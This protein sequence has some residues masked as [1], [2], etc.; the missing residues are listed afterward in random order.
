MFLIA[1]GQQ[2]MSASQTIVITRTLGLEKVAIWSVGTRVFTLL[3]LLTRRI[4][5]FSVPPLAEILVRKEHAR[6]RE[7]FKAVTVL[8][9][10]VGGLAA[11]LAGACNASFVTFW[12]HG[13]ITWTVGCDVLLG[14]WLIV[15]A[16]QY[17]HVGFVGVTKDI[18]FARWI[19][20]VEGVVFVVLASFVARWAGLAGIIGCSAVCTIC[21]SGAYGMRRSCEYF[22]IPWTEPGWNWLKP[23]GRTLL[24][25]VPLA[26]AVWWLT[27][28]LA[29]WQR[30]LL[31]GVLLGSLGSCLLLRYGLPI[32]LKR[33]LIQ[34]LP[35]SVGRWMRR[36]MGDLS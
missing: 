4:F 29:E 33:E 27:E 19:F 18:R 1:L 12:T 11:V 9:I 7:R 28:P 17:C 8:S 24:G 36:V 26:V 20:L 5:D 16:A 14:V 2:L 25:L 30:M 22:A 31:R 35:E 23:L 15:L 32:E 3:W 13:R 21:I 34:R 10:S 6:L